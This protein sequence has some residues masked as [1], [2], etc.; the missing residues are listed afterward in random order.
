MSMFCGKD[1]FSKKKS[2]KDHKLRNLA[3][4]CVLYKLDCCNDIISIRQSFSSIVVYD[5]H[6][7]FS[8]S[9]YFGKE[10][11]P[12]EAIEK[13]QFLGFLSTWVDKTSP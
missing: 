6:F 12:K 4:R 9:R 5:T 11:Q 3:V 2:F 13:Y 8:N 10:L 7:I 1:E